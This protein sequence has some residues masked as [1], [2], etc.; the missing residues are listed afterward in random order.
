[1]HYLNPQYSYLI[2]LYSVYPL[3]RNL[4]KFPRLITLFLYSYIFIIFYFR[5]FKLVLYV[6]IDEFYTFLLDFIFYQ[7]EISLWTF[8]C[9][10]YQT[11]CYEIILPS[12]LFSSI[13][14]GLVF[15]PRQINSLLWTSVLSFVNGANNTYLLDLFVRIKWDN[16]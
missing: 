2:L 6:N 5:Y 15:L 12:L 1:M 10:W 13:F 14:Q 16:G 9:F 3:P 4:F 8:K 7:D 11:L